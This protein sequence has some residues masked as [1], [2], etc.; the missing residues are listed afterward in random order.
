MIE[1]MVASYLEK[2]LASM[3]HEEKRRLLRALQ[4]LTAALQAGDEHTARNLLYAMRVPP[5]T[6]EV[7]LGALCDPTLAWEPAADEAAPDSKQ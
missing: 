3:P 7:V 4:V 1:R 5:N 6:V 2:N